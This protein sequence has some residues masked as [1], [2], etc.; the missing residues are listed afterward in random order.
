MQKNY[1]ISFLLMNQKEYLQYIGSRR[2]SILD[3]VAHPTRRMVSVTWV[4]HQL[5][6]PV[7]LTKKK[8]L[9]V[10]SDNIF[11]ANIY[12]LWYYFLVR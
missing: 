12:T 8:K 4:P 10:A 7:A 5:Y 1:S 3:F 9:T 6:S 2:E 11:N